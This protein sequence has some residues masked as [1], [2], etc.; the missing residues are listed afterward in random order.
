MASLDLS[1]ERL[2]LTG[3]T[4]FVGHSLLDYCA[5][6]HEQGGGPQ[7][8]VLS[9]QPRA[10]LQRHPHWR[11]CA[12]LHWIEG[13]LLGSFRSGHPAYAQLQHA[14]AT[15]FV[16]A[17]ADTHGK[18]PDDWIEQICTGT[19]D[20]LQ[21]AH[22]QGVRRYLFVSSGAVYGRQPDTVAALAEDY[23][24][25]PDPTLPGS[26]YG[27]AK[28]LA[29]QWCTVYQ[30]KGSMACMIA[31]CFAFAGPHLPL[32]GPYALG[33]FVHD[34]L[35]AE[36]IT[37]TGDGSPVRS[38]LHQGD[39]AHWLMWLLHHGKGGTAV[40]VG[41]A[42]PI[43]LLALAERVRDL[44]APQKKV[45]VLGKPN[46]DAA[47]SRYLPDTRRAQAL[48]L[49]ETRDLDTAILEMAECHR[50]ERTRRM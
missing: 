13:D 10:F 25:A 24:G 14:A 22:A 37:L 4:G 20:T 6:A 26:V 43:S 46:P 39:M 34:A 3:G 31:R 32:S 9:R 42:T 11:N 18:Q 45:V 7:V 38:Y 21:F 15:L 50:R 28:R 36:Q 44:L 1:G 48:G 8:W 47:R 16:H 2:L 5:A 30:A 35:F 33:N 12:W 19:R 27:Q 49:A 23:P 29:E 40:N 17:A 41:G